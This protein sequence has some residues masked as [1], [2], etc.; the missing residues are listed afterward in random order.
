MDID[1]FCRPPPDQGPLIGA[2]GVSSQRNPEGALPGLQ[3]LEE[4]LQLRWQKSKG[5]FRFGLLTALSAVFERNA[6]AME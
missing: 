5:N 1:E 6:V 2:A 4:Y 3:V